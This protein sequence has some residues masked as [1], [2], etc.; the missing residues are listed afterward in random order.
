MWIQSNKCSRLDTF[1]RMLIVVNFPLCRGDKFCQYMSKVKQR[2]NEDGGKRQNYGGRLRSR[3]FKVNN[4]ILAALE[5]KV[6]F[7]G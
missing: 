2:E 4:S 5:D 6:S 1:F 3:R 7:T